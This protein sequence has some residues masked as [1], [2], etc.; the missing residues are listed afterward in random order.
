MSDYNNIGGCS[1]A[2]V[3]NLN[4]PINDISTIEIWPS[5]SCKYCNDE[6]QYSYSVDGVCWSCYMSYEDALASTVELS[7]DFYLRI[8]VNG[9]ITT[10]TDSD[11]ETTDY[12]TQLESG[13]TFSYCT[14][15]TSSNTYSPYSNLDGALALQAQLAETV[16]CMF[17]IPIYYF[18]LT[19]NVGSKDITFKE[20]ALY[21]VESVKQIKL[22]I[23]DGTMPSSKPE[24]SDFG[25]DWQ[26]D[27]ETEISKSQFATAFGNNAQPMEGDLIYIPMMK[28]MWMVN[29][30]YEEKNGNLMWMS[31]TFKVA[32]VKYQEKRSV[33]LGDTQSM[34]DN[35][36]K[37]KYEDLFGD[38]ESINSGIEAT[39]GPKYAANGPLPVY[40]SDACR[41]YVTSAGIDFSSTNLYYK[42]TLIADSCYKYTNPDILTTQIVYQRKYCGEMG[43]MSFIF[44]P[45]STTYSGNLITLAGL[46]LNIEQNTRYCT[47]TLMNNPTTKLTVKAGATYFVYLRWSK[48]LNVIEFV[49]APYV[50]PD[51]I[52][53]YKLQPQHY[54]F[55]LDNPYRSVSKYTVEMTQYEKK[56]VILR[57]FNGTITNF[58]VFDVY[59][60]NVSEILQMFP[61]HQH[62]IIN[63]TARKLID[64]HGQSMS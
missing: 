23:A 14:S 24:F 60:D 11:E 51:G 5:D 15:S 25:L 46:K 28:R 33:D 44:Y 48:E 43:T 27:W 57:G 56:D 13:F 35:F 37:T 50:Y 63:D 7:S 29:E 2:Q 58:K 17:G 12:T 39:E 59:D 31:T 4:Y 18:K 34:V 10:V 52:A 36:V 20:Y 19:P 21:D 64:M 1:P 32:L 8:K 40:E 6:L 45:N 47:L 61:T 30:A 42:G 54:S 49:A 9:P 22:L 38:E 53:L 62:L 26:S 16:A 41:K 55:N 3:M